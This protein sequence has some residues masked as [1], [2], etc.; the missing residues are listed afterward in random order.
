MLTSGGPYSQQG[1]KQWIQEADPNLLEALEGGLVLDTIGA[2][3]AAQQQH[4]QQDAGAV[5]SSRPS[6]AQLHLHSSSSDDWLAAVQAAADRVGVEANTVA[7]Q[8]QEVQALQGVLGHVHL[9]ARGVPAVTLSH[10][11]GTVRLG[12][13]QLSSM[14]DTVNG[15]QLDKMLEATQVSNSSCSCTSLCLHY[16]TDNP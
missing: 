6:A 9:A 1:L 15:V 7:E 2:S 8:Q 11:S 14:S 12:A 3:S 10:L 13:P 16:S 5:G 4:Q